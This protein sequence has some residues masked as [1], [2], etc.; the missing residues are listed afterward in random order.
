[1]HSPKLNDLMQE[2]M[3]EA[4]KARL[5]AC[6]K[7]V[8]IFPMAKIVHPEHVSIGEHTRLCDYSFI[9][10]EGGEV[11]IG[12]YCDFEPYS[13][14]WG[15]GKMR[16]GNFVNFGP[17]MKIMGNMYDYRQGDI[18]VG[19]VEQTH[20]GIIADELIIE[21]HVYFGADVTVL[22]NVHY[23]GEGAIIGAQSLVNCDLEPWGVYVGTP[24]RKIGERPRTAIDKVKEYGFE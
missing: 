7:E 20:A 1:M 23:I 18:M 5:K 12:K 9:H 22:G 6:G 3:G 16:I 19:T 14:I 8:K 24:A 2:Y 4:V 15:A 11:T 21:D 17:G 10:P 13:L